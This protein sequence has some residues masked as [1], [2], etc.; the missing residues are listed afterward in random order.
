M[1]IPAFHPLKRILPMSQNK[2]Y[3]LP[4]L[5]AVIA[6]ISIVAAILLPVFATAREKARQMTCI[7][8]MKQIG[9][10]LTQYQQEYDQ[11][12]PNGWD[13]YGR[14]SGWAWQVYPYVKN[15][16]AF[17]CPDDAKAGAATSS[18]GMNA[19]AGVASK[20]LIP[21]G[22]DGRSLAD[23]SKPERTVLLFEVTNGSASNY[24][25]LASHDIHFR[26]ADN[27]IE[28]N[29]R[30]ASGF[31]IGDKYDPSGAGAEEASGTAG[32]GHI[33]YATGYMRHSQR[34][35]HFAAPAGRHSG[36]SNFLMADNHA[37]WLAPGAVSAGYDDPT[38]AYCGDDEHSTSANTD[39]P[40]STINATFSVH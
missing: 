21:G 14:V 23:Y 37:Q 29:G 25:D 4:A 24:Y 27:F 12:G 38:H 32:D 26:G 5:L 18:Y 17:R 6:I 28:D 10:A 9:L 2:G 33:K 39:C 19:N 1:N 30:S 31:G 40:D 8:N 7:G 11:K 34:T 22:A 36:G 3:T 16:G 20:N 15:K 13:P 35:P